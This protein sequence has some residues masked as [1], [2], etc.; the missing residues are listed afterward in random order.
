MKV[1][2]LKLKKPGNVRQSN[3][4]RT[5][6][7]RE[8]YTEQSVAVRAREQREKEERE[9]EGRSRQR[10]QVPIEIVLSFP[11]RGPRFEGSKLCGPHLFRK[12]THTTPS[13]AFVSFFLFLLRNW[14][15][16]KA[17][18]TDPKR[19]RKCITTLDVMLLPQLLCN[20]TCLAFA[21]D[22]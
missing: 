12:Y 18:K 1:R 9:R 10:S 2:A 11:F 13:W 14:S 7:S 19:W 16:S 22:T 15:W 21:F 17:L 4:R 20:D 8:H 6:Y 3:R 5:V